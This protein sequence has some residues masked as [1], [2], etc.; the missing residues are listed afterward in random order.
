MLV[1]AVGT[2]YTIEFPSRSHHDI[3]VQTSW[4]SRPRSAILSATRRSKYQMN[5]AIIWKHLGLWL[6]A[7]KCAIVATGNLPTNNIS[8]PSTPVT[9]PF[10]Y[11]NCLHESH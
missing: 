11:R 4:R 8:C 2:K 6:D 7:Q 10:G 3:L 5:P 9:P 1:S